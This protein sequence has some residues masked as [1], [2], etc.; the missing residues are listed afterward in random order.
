VTV[1][2]LPLVIRETLASLGTFRGYAAMG[3]DTLE[4]AKAR[5]NI[6]ALSL[7][8]TIERIEETSGITR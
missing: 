8:E 1:Y 3:A 4:L 6:L 7:E 2:P 5:L